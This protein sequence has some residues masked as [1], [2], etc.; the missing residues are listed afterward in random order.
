MP[1]CAGRL[2]GS[3]R[4]FEGAGG[5]SHDRGSSLGNHGIVNEM[6]TGLTRP[7]ITLASLLQV[8]A[9]EENET[10]FTTAPPETLQGHRPA[11]F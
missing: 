2:H 8:R 5:L 1:A 9:V 6:F 7:Q 11:F 3:L 10:V 4:K